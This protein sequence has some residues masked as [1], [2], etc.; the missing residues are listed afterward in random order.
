MQNEY[1]AIIRALEWRYHECTSIIEKLEL[2]RMLAFYYNRVK[3]IRPTTTVIMQSIM[4]DE[5]I[6]YENNQQS[7]SINRNN[8]SSDY[9]FSNNT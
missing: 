2:T 7:A 6:N 5:K 8:C 1:T 9:Y 3:S 4:N